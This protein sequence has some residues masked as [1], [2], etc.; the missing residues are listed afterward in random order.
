[1]EWPKVKNIII[2]ILLLVNGFL[3]FLVGG[4]QHRVRHYEQSALTRA[5]QILEQ[6]GISV[7]E[8]ALKQAASS[9]PPSLTVSRDLTREGEIAHILLG[10]DAVCT[11]QSGGLYVYSSKQGTAIFRANGDFTFTLSDVSPGGQDPADHAAALLKK[12]GLTGE[13]I[14]QD[15]SPG[16]TTVFFRQLLEGTPLFS[17][18][19]V[20]EYS[21]T[22]LRSISGTLLT[23]DTAVSTAESTSTLDVSTALIRFLAGILDSGDVCSAVTGFRPGY[24]SVQSFGSTGYLTPVW[25]VST[26]ISD[27][28]L[29]GTTGSLIR[30]S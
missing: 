26:N 10:S 2:L 16:T 22:R 6:N 30:A 21:S 29:D 28:Y 12:M 27:Y 5:A 18:R 7:S 1:M 20:F 11:D 17:C 19:L 15:S 14:G 13:L 8:E 23:A 9:A 24:L 3:L 25:L 4:Q